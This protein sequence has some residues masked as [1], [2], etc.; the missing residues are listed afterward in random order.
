MSS[1]KFLRYKD[2]KGRNEAIRQQSYGRMIGFF[3]VLFA[4]DTEI[5]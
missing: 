2:E 4:L 3:A 5:S 1:S